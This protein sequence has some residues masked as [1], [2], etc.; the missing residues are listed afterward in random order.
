MKKITLLALFCAL[1]TCLS[2]QFLLGGQ[3][4][5]SSIKSKED[6]GGDD[7][8]SSTTLI[9]VMPRLAYASGNLWYGLDAG[10][11][12]I[13]EKD[14]FLNETNE[15][16]TTIANIAPFIRYTKRP[17]DDLGIWIE[18]QAGASFGS[19]KNDAGDKVAKYTGFN[20]GLRPGVIFFIGEHLSFEAS[21]GRLGF[22][23]FTTENPNDSDD[24]ETL[25]Q[26]GLILNGNSILLDETAL[27]ISN[28]F[29]FGVNWLF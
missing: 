28:G 25:T 2:A 12:L 1:T 11:S 15:S 20:I 24:K 23:S 29:Q 26:V 13:N 14:E 6:G 21:F 8:E 22:T 18:G 7:D 16:K 19:R 5:F 4:N 27:T 17:V 9:T 3:L 10:V